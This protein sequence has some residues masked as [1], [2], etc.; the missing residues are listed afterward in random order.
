M[1]TILVT[2]ASG[3]LGRSVIGHL[4]SAIPASRIIALVRDPEKVKDLSAKGVGVRVGTYDDAAS[5]VQAFQGVDTLFFTSASDLE[6]RV[7]QH[8]NVVEAAKQAGIRHVVYTSFQRKNT[9]ATSPI[10]FVAEAHLR[11]EEWLRTSGMTYTFLKNTLYMDMLPMFIGDQVLQTG[12][13][14][15]PAGEGKGA[16]LTRE[17]MAEIGARVLLTPGHENKEYDVTGESSVTLADI[18]ALI[19][20]ASGKNIQYVSPPV[21]EF[22]KAL[23]GA[24]VPELMVNISTAF[25]VAIAQG[26]FEKTNPTVSTLLGRAPVSI[27]QYLNT[28]YGGSAK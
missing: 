12:T 15:L 21:I 11:T 22:K 19:G 20:K 1:S 23:L 8:K 28:V 13:V 26:E 3:Q 2:G 24:G 7:P 9:T 16:Y 4:L 17:D 10:A 27:A 5:L 14:Y 25:A 18:A 6:K